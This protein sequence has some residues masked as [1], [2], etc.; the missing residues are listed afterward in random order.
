MENEKRMVTERDVNLF[1]RDD[2]F[3]IGR[4]ECGEDVLGFRGY[5][6]AE[7]PNGKRWVYRESF[8][9]SKK[10]VDEEG[11]L[12][13]YNDREG[14][15]KLQACLKGLVAE[16]LENGLEIPGPDWSPTSPCYGSESWTQEDECSLMDDA[17]WSAYLG[18][19]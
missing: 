17:E 15:A 9:L 16:L 2:Y 6:Y 19:H 1:T 4:G 13:S 7:A 5:I 12:H 18:R 3:S 10:Y 8:D 14:E 11:F